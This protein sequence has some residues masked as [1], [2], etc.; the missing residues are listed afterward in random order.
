MMTMSNIDPCVQAGEH[1]E[2]CVYVKGDH[3]SN[4]LQHDIALL[5]S[6]VDTILEHVAGI[7]QAFQVIA[8]STN[9]AM[10]FLDDSVIGKMLG[11]FMGRDNGDGQPNS[12]S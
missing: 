8:E 4:Y 6:K 9:Q 1:V 7:E 10:G 5:H 12:G 3:T 2:G 11:K